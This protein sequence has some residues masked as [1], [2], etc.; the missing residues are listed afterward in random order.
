M[1]SNNSVPE[2]DLDLEIDQDDETNTYFNDLADMEL[3]NYNEE[4]NV[5]KVRSKNRNKR[6]IKGKIE[7][8]LE[9]IRQKKELEYLY[10][11]WN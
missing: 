11:D 6:M 8:Q 9:K 7:M 10:D 4:S 5:Q 1:N 2:S 3:E